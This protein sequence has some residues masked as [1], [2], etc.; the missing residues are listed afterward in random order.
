MDT[1]ARLQVGIDMSRKRAD[2]ALLKPDGKP[3]V[4]HRAFSN[5][6]RGA[7]EVKQFLLET[8]KQYEYTGIDIAVEATGYYWLPF[9]IQLQAG[10]RFSPL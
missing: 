2:I 6:A 5:S 1:K 3:L 10:C 8:A 4:M 9:F 7:E